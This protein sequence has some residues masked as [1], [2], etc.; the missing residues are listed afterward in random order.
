MDS[1]KGQDSE[2]VDDKEE[3]FAVGENADWVNPPSV[4]AD[5]YGPG[6]FLI[7]AVRD[8]ATIECTCGV[9]EGDVIP[10]HSMDCEGALARLS[11]HSQA[12]TLSL[13]G[14][15]RELP[16]FHLKHC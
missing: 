10:F 2:P 6:P 9:T 5:S 7:T 8:T 16:G 1:Q 14:G 12:V 11:P 15:E 4:P 13:P 3:I